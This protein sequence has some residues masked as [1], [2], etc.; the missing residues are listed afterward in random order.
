M[1]LATGDRAKRE[2]LFPVDIIAFTLAGTGD[3][4]VRM[5]GVDRQRKE[6]EA[7]A[8]LR[9]FFEFFPGFIQNGVIVEAPV[10]AVS[11][12]GDRGFQLFSAVQVVKTV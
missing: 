1:L 12:V 6:R 2:V 3:K 4:A 11:G 7:F 8:G 9:K 10:I 5:V